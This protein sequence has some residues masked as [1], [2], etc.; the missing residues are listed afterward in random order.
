[1]NINQFK[2]KYASYRDADKIEITCDDPRH[3]PLGEIIVIGKQPAKRNILKNGGEKFVCRQCYMKYNNPMNQEGDSRQ[4]DELIDVFCPC[5]D[6]QGDSSRKMKKSCYY[7]TMAEPYLQ[8]CGSCSQRGKEIGEEQ[9]EKIRLAMKGVPKSDEFKKKL[10]EYWAAHPERREEATAILL[11][12]RYTEG[13]FKGKRH[14]DE[15]KELMSNYMSGREYTPEH[16][17]NIS[18]GRKK[19]LTET[20]GF[21]REHREKIS[22]ATIEQYR[23]GFNPKTHHRTGWHESPKAGKVF[24][25]ST[26]E[27]K[28]YMKL[29]DDETVQMYWTEGTSVEYFHP[30]KKITS[31][32][33]IDIKIQYVD[34]SIL[35]VEVKPEAWLTDDVVIAK[36]EAA[37]GLADSLGCKFE[38]WTEMHLFGHVYNEKNMRKF[39]ERWETC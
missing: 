19:M 36:I 26:Y 10:A 5:E 9:R 33:I 1:M 22:A 6:H 38:V 24:Y 21:T 30:I 2:D 4:T 27:K 16:C 12:N 39:A 32:Y 35:L 37:E 20:G 11:E 18:E 17:E 13:G 3:E 7:G 15:Y 25:R 31:K 34:G 29:D 14:T 28:A 8:M 23:K